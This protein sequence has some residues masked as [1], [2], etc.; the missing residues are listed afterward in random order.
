MA[1]EKAAKEKLDTTPRGV[2]VT[3]GRREPGTPLRNSSH[4]GTPRRMG[5]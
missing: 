1:T 4:S 5:L 2:I 3:P